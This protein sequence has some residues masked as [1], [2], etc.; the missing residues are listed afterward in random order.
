M[1]T[2]PDAMATARLPNRRRT[3]RLITLYAVLALLAIVIGIAVGV[4]PHGTH[5]NAIIGDIAVPTELAAPS[6]QSVIATAPPGV[7]TPTPLATKPPPPTT[8][9]PTEAA[10]TAAPPTTAPAITVNQNTPQG[11]GKGKG[12]GKNDKGD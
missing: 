11:S 5:S 4:Q 8:V 9:P 12:K 2:E 7:P 10:P 3:R 1:I 6:E